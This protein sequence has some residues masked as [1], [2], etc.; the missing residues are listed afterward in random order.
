MHGDSSRANRQSEAVTSGRS[1]QEYKRR[2]GLNAV[3]ELYDSS[4]RAPVA[5]GKAERLA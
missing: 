5:G 1:F 4:I 3:A 2:F